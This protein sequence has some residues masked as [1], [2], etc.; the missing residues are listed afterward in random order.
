M[1]RE[2]AERAGCA[3]RVEGPK[4][5]AGRWDRLRIGQVVTN[6]LSNA[7][8]FGHGHPIDVTVSESGDTVRVV[9]S[10]TGVG[11]PADALARIFERFER[12]SSD[13]H[14]PG[15]GLGL[16]ITRQIVEACHGTISVQSELGSGSTFC[17]EL[18]RLT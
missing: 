18:P 12:A 2:S 15:L 4:A 11:I 1:V 16:W 5:I 8:K 14:F 7:I 3:I 10:D 13:R 9:V 17:V 6:L